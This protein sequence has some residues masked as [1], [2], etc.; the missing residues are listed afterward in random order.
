MNLGKV[1]LMHETHI[2]TLVVNGVK[3]PGFKLIEEW[4]G[5]AKFEH[6]EKGTL[7]VAQPEGFANIFGQ[8]F[9]SIFNQPKENR[10]VG[11]DFDVI[12]VSPG[13]LDAILIANEAS[14]AK[15]SA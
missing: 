4:E 13:V 11:R 14:K 9:E 5:F 8:I 1:K 10:T 12:K 15:V 2:F 7:I 3:I 6:P